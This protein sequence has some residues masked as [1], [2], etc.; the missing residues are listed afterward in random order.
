M[1]EQKVKAL[2]QNKGL[3]QKTGAER[4][5]YPERTFSRMLNGYTPI[6]DTDVWKIAQALGVTPNELYEIA[7][8]AGNGVKIQFAVDDKII[9]ET[10]AYDV[11]ALP[12][13][14]P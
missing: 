5:G 13:A 8:H 6:R 2:I 14:C 1:I 11:K 7:D 9:G 4:A 12:Q 3:L 10:V